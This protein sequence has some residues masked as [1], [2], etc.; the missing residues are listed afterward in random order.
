MQQSHDACRLGVGD[1]RKLLLHLVDEVLGVEGVLQAE[2]E[3]VYGEVQARARAV[4]RGVEGDGIHRRSA[5]GEGKLKAL[6]VGQR[7]DASSSER[8]AEQVVEHEVDERLVDV[9]ADVVLRKVDAE[10]DADGGGLLCGG[11]GV[12]RLRRSGGTALI[13]AL[14]GVADIAAQQA[15]Y[16][17]ELDLAKPQAACVDVDGIAERT[18]L[19]SGEFR[20]G[21]EV[22]EVALLDQPGRAEIVHLKDGGVE[23]LA[24]RDRHAQVAEQDAAQARRDD[25]AE[26]DVGFKL[27]AEVDVAGGE[28]RLDH[29]RAIEFGI[30][31]I[32]PLRLTVRVEEL[33]R[34]A[35]NG[36][37]HLVVDGCTGAVLSLRI[38]RTFVFDVFLIRRSEGGDEEAVGTQHIREQPDHPARERVVVVI[39]TGLETFA[40][41]GEID[42]AGRGE[43]EVVRKLARIHIEQLL[44]SHFLAVLSDDVVAGVVDVDVIRGVDALRADVHLG[45]V[46]GD[47]EVLGHLEVEC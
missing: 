41:H 4:H 13:D 12:L 32:V 23:R 38:E 34:V 46:D 28:R 7:A 33:R 25:R 17:L 36:G 40:G 1:A 9:D 45:D 39:V 15:R 24:Q 2:G 44:V 6:D 14:I 35:R 37:A 43:S 3:V 29:R 21:F 18:L 27:D 19:L 30:V 16:A 11:I 20:L 22:V 31:R 26:V 42:V 47:A 5:E 8:L 10:R